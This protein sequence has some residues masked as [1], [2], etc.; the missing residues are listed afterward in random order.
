MEVL[1]R[2]YPR[3]PFP[4]NNLG[5]AYERTGELEKATQEYREAVALNPQSAIPYQNLARTLLYLDRRKDAKAVMEEALAKHL[6]TM[7]LHLWLYELAVEEGDKAGMEREVRWAVDKP[8]EFWMAM[9]QGSAALF[10]GKLQ[11]SRELARRANELAVREKLKSQ[12]A[13]VAAF[14]AMQTAL[15][16]DCR[17]TRQAE[18]MLSGAPRRDTILPVALAFC[19]RL[20]EAQALVERVSRRW[21]ADSQLN[22]ADLPLARAAIELQL[23]NPAR[24]VE[25]LHS[26]GSYERYRP[27][28][29]YV[30]GLGYL[31]AGKGVEAAAEFQ[32]IAGARGADPLWPGRALAYVELARAY[33]L[34]ATSEQGADADAARAKARNAYQD[35]LTLW[36]D[37]DPDIPIL[38][39]A[40]AEY[41]KL[42]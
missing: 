24:A 41:K 22:A 31:R 30:R 5:Y 3:D 6:D 2:T 15:L 8:E 12:V 21:P 36:K 9:E 23:G 19:G 35:F 20:S 39:Q 17:L 28:I 7:N 11:S 14:F 27:D 10:E 34:E 32:K 42:K 33:V 1:R 40:K 25:S 16:G 4:V 13:G 26:V 37:A 18:T 38:K 29:T